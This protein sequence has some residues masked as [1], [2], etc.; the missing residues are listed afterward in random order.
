MKTSTLLVIY[1]A[2]SL[3]FGIGFL[4]S[5]NL[6]LSMYGLELDALGIFLAR[7][8]G[9]AMLALAVLTWSTR[10]GILVLLKRVMQSCYPYLFSKVLGLCCP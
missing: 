1:A 6:I 4:F 7:I 10:K 9:A 8:L 2:I 3:I 5:P